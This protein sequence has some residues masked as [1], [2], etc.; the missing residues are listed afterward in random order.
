MLSGEFDPDRSVATG[1]ANYVRV[2]RIPF[3]VQAF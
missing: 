2:R 3:W 1:G